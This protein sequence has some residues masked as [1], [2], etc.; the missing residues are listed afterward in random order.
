MEYIT[1]SLGRISIVVVWLLS[2]LSM[3]P[4]RQN[5]DQSKSVSVND[6]K[7]LAAEEL[8]KRVRK[9]VEPT[10]PPSV[11]FL[12]K[13]VEKMLVVEVAVNE[14]GNVD[15]ARAVSGVSLMKDAAVEVAKD[16]KFSPPK[17]EGLS[18]IVGV[19]VFEPPLETLYSRMP[20]NIS[21]Y[22]E[23]SEK[24]PQSWEEHCR[25]A[26]AYQDRR[27]Y[28]EA[29][30]EFK[31]AISHSPQAV[32][33]FG[34]GWAHERLNQYD[35][36]LEAY[37]QAVRLRPDFA[38]AHFAIGAMYG[39]LAGLNFDYSFHES[40]RLS[41]EAT[42]YRDSDL[43]T[44]RPVKKPEKVDFEKIDKAVKAF[45]QAIRVRPDPDVKEIAFLGVAGTYRDAGKID[46]A[47]KAYEEL[48]NIK[49]EI[50][51]YG[52]FRWQK[53]EFVAKDINVLAV[54]CEENGR[55]AEAIKHFQRTVDLTQYTSAYFEAYWKIVTL[56]K[57]IGNE[58]EAM[59]AGQKM[60][61]E[62]DGYIKSSV[63]RGIRGNVHEERGLIYEAIGSYKEAIESYKR[64]A[65]LLRG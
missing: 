45:T 18:R 15:S 26:T 9:R 44:T 12:E 59:K 38:E 16:W 20:R 49:L 43:I 35:H 24:N 10:F 48:I 46:L 2:C 54:I 39:Q 61:A 1:T 21:Y 34:L 64:A 13:G 31:R 25:L 3:A 32:A 11:I 40:L 7:R 8:L 60:L 36:A 58:A 5:N 37:Q 63:S 28:R 6:P 27:L 53:E 22:Q 42:G 4:L 62:T 57:K 14:E 23:Q 41:V 65:D 55:Y 33:Y 56:Y 19:I 47:I 50:K 52:V 29:A 30:E 51:K 17:D